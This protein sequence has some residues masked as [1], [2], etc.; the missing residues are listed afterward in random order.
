TPRLLTNHFRARELLGIPC[1]G[2]L[3]IH[4]Y[5]REAKEMN[6]KYSAARPLPSGIEDGEDED[7]EPY[8]PPPYLPPWMD[9]HTLV[10]CAFCTEKWPIAQLEL[11]VKHDHPVQFFEKALFR[12][13]TCKQVSFYCPWRYAE[14]WESCS[15]CAPGPIDKCLS[16]VAP[17]QC[18][19]YTGGKIQRTQLFPLPEHAGNEVRACRFCSL[20]MSPTR[21]LQHM[22]ESHGLHHFTDAPYP[23]P[24]CG[25]VGFYAHEEYKKHAVE[26]DGSTPLGLVDDPYAIVINVAEWK[27]NNKEA[28][29][30]TYRMCFNGYRLR[31]TI[32]AFEWKQV[33]AACPLKWRFM[34][35][36]RVMVD[37]LITIHPFHS[38]GPLKCAGCETIF[39]DLASLSKHANQ[40][41]DLGNT[42]C[43]GKARVSLN[44]T[45]STAKVNLNILKASR[46]STMASEGDSVLVQYW[47]EYLKLKKYR[48]IAVPKPQGP[49]PL[50]NV[51]RQ[52]IIRIPGNPQFRRSHF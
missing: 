16:S 10:E 22:K 45:E 37:H 4:D 24:R 25:E 48:I 30:A 31:G 49:R 26:C 17:R 50:P 2:E 21:L 13:K 7:D 52:Q 27:K 43:F 12:C 41:N 39:H 36:L 18:G 1:R 3:I 33:C 34:A 14:H 44:P 42:Q 47:K 19:G 38:A 51:V 6:K 32:A 9:V 29:F 23:C 20:E 40:Q 28:D 11:H 15:P 5:Q 46:G 8:D 35:P